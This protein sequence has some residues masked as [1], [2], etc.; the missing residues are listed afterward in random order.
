MCIV[1]TIVIVIGEQLVIFMLHVYCDYSADVQPICLPTIDD[2]PT[3]DTT[4][5]ITGFG[6]ITKHPFDGKYLY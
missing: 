5:F 2:I 3:D 1:V 4:C 6:D